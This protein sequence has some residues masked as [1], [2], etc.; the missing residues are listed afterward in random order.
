MKDPPYMPDCDPPALHPVA[1]SW[2]LL[3][4]L[5]DGIR[6]RG[7]LLAVAVVDDLD[8]ARVYVHQTAASQAPAD[9]T[10]VWAQAAPGATAGPDS[11][12][13]PYPH[14]TPMVAVFTDQH[15]LGVWAP[16]PS[17]PGGL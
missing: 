8:Q 4:W 3:V 7:R 5:H 16:V 1:A 9:D 10:Y 12:W 15:R 6:P 14:G 13:V 2:Q 17:K 11:Q